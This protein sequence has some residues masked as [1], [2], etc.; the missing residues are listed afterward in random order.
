MSGVSGYAES[1]Q[2]VAVGIALELVFVE[3]LATP[4]PSKEAAH[5]SSA[6]ASKEAG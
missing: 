1:G 6:L 5:G 3:L 4:M 2:E